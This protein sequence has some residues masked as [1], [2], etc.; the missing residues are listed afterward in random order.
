MF[1]VWI[2]PLMFIPIVLWGYGM[3][4]SLKRSIYGLLNLRMNGALPTLL[5]GNLSAGGTGK[6]PMVLFLIDSFSQDR[7]GVLSRGYGRKSKGFM[8]VDESSTFQD[9]GD[10][11]L[12]I[13]HA[14]IAPVFVCE[15]RLAGLQRIKESQQADWVIMDDGFQ[16]LAL[17]ATKKV[18]LTSFQNPFWKESFSLPIGN[19]REFQGALA[20]ADVLVVT[21]CPQGLDQSKA[22]EF[23]GTLKFDKSKIF[24]AHYKQTIPVSVQ[25]SVMEKKAILISGVVQQKGLDES[26]SDWEII[27]YINYKDHHEFSQSDIRFWLKMCKE[28]GVN[29]IILTRKDWQRIKNNELLNLLLNEG[30]N[31]NEI[32]TEVEILWNQKDEFLKLV[33]PL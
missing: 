27:D 1:E 4:T 9:V 5:V 15:N 12:E 3:F 6:T 21:K 7:V 28:K 13:A 32:H 14:E 8:S 18:L 16:H 24:F 33:Y 10:E 25:G 17:A 22:R 20:D 29:S 31:I 26:L 30:I 2:I 23:I 11:A 19:L